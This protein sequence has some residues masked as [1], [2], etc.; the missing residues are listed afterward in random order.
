MFYF[1]KYSL[2]LCSGNRSMAYRNVVLGSWLRCCWRNCSRTF[3]SFFPTSLNIQ[4]IAL[5][6]K[7]WWSCKRIFAMFNVSWYWLLRMNV[8]VATMAMRFSQ[9]FDDLARV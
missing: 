4:P 3:W 5:W 6:I 7:S 2:R 1:F 9:R 8:K